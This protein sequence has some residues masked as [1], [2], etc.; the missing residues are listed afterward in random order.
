MTAIVNVSI[1]GTNQGKA[2]DRPSEVL[3]ELS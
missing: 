1:P 2:I 3:K